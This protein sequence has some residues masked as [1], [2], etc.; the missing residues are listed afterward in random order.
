MVVENESR[1]SRQPGEE[2]VKEAAREARNVAAI[3]GREQWQARG[4][5]VP[6]SRG[7]SKEIEKGCGIDIPAV[8]PVP[9]CRL[10][11]TLQVAGD[12]RRFAGAGRPTDPTQT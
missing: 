5:L 6:R 2:Q 9:D 1:G 7:F 8:H 11:A 4:S 3:L 10:T 12:Q